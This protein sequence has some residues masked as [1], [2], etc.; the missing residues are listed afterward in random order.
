[1]CLIKSMTRELQTHPTKESET[2]PL[3][4]SPYNDITYAGDIGQI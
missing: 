3:V 4:T 1:M 2:P